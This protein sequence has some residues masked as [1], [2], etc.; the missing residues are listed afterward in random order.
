ME[1][2]S[3]Y[4]MQEYA[5][6]IVRALLPINVIHSTVL[7]AG[8]IGNVFVIFIFAAKMRKYQRESRYFIP[9]LAFYDLMVCITSGIYFLTNTF[10]WTSFHSDELC[11]TLLFFVIQTM[12]TSDAFLLANRS[13]KIHQD[14]PSL[15]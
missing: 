3:T 15:C 7:V 1:E 4:L 8:I 14:L 2:N 11:K 13:S 12:M 5:G 10:F 6:N 9:A